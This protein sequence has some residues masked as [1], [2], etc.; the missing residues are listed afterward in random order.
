LLLRLLCVRSTQRKVAVWMLTNVLQPQQLPLATA[1]KIYKMRWEN[2]GFFRTYKRTLGKVKLSSRTVA[3]VHR[4]VEGSL[5]AV[6]LLLAQGAW[7]LVVLGEKE[8]VSSPRRVLQEIRREIQGRLGK[9]QHAQFLQR[10]GEAKRE[11]R[12]RQ[13]SK[14]SRSWPGRE[15]HKPP[16][17]P[18][19]RELTEK[20]KTF[21]NQELQVA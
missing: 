13:S 8:A 14:V 11:R 9:R 3:L 2:K 18:K 15:E 7:A 6:Q 21:L 10:L 5:L 12:P 17:P 19:L 20:L 4:E 16:K 1:A